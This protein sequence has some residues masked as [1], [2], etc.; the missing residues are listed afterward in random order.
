MAVA[1]SDLGLQ[2][3]LCLLILT[4][5]HS[6]QRHFNKHVALFVFGDSLFDPGNNNYI[7]TTTELKANFWPYGESYFHP[8]SGRFSDG[9]I[10]PD[11]I[12]EF[13][14]LPLI[15]AY[16]DPHN[17]EFLYGVNF[18]SAGA[19][20]FV[21]S[22]N[23]VAVDLKTQLQYFTDLVKHYRQNLG[24]AKAE[25]L[26][27][28]AVYLFSCGSNDYESL[29]DNNDNS[30]NFKQFVEVVIGN[31]TDVLKGVH[32][33]GGRKFGIGTFRS[34][35]CLLPV[36][37][38]RPD[39]TC[40]EQLNILASLHDKAL[41][42]RLQDLAQQW[43]GFMYAKYEL[44]IE[45][46]KRMKNPSKYGFKVGGECAC[47]GTGRFRAINSCGGKREIREFELCD[48]PNDYLLFDPYHPTEAANRQ[49]A[50]MFW[51]GDSKVSSPYNLKALVSGYVCITKAKYPNSKE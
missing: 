50:E 26:L 18:A 21:E 22:Q 38:E 15:P 44:Q 42:R 49:L 31:F 30:L 17:N 3:V 23:G 16:L 47:C 27:S 6:S 46:T 10:I 41:S 4:G 35:G 13:A 34:L 36:R 43:E 5:C 25:Q 45:I 24:D 37:A 20:V 29:L 19:A 39:N 40:D 33:Q 48:N 12:A 11:F 9:R 8:P 51:N 14:G 2:L 1:K 28:D 32:E 7:N